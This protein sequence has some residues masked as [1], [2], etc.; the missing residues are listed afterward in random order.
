MA[1]TDSGATRTAAHLPKPDSTVEADGGRLAPAAPLSFGDY[2]VVGDLGAGGMGRVYKAA[3]RKLSRYVAIK[4][5]LTPDAFEASRFRGEASITARLEHPNITR[6]FEIETTADGHPYLVLEYAEGGSLDREL[7]GQPQEPRRAAEMAETLAKAIQYAHDQ[8]VIHRDLKPANVLRAK[9]GTLKLTDFGLAKQYELSS[10]LTPSGAL[11]GTPSYM[12]PEQAS[13]S[14]RDVGPAAD[15]Y[16]LGAI[17]Y[18]LLTGRP[19]FRGVTMVETLEQVRWADPAPPSRLAPRLPRDLGTI[20]LKCLAKAPA[21][22]Y[23]TAADLAADLRR[24]MDGETI[25]ARPAPAWERGWR[26]FRRRPWESA[27]VAAGVLLAVLLAAGAVYAM[28]QEA[29]K[30]HD[31]DL[32]AE[33][34]RA[35]HL[36]REAEREAA[37]RLRER[38]EK[39]RRALDAIKHHL[40][41]GELRS[42]RGLNNLHG[43]LADYYKQYIDEALT[44]PSPD[45]AALAELAYGVGEQAHQSGRHD[46]AGLLFGQARDGFAAVAGADPRHRP[47]LGDALVKVARVLYD[48]NRDDEAAAACAEAERLWAAVYAASDGRARDTA[49]LQL[50]EV[51][52]IRGELAR[53]R[54]DIPAARDAF[55]RAI[56]HRRRVAGLYPGQSVDLLLAAEPAERAWAVRCL[57]ELGRG[58]GYRGDEFLTLGEVPDADRDYWDSHRVRQKVFD[59]LKAA[60]PA[61]DPAEFELARFQLGRSWMNLA[62]VQARHRAYATAKQNAHEALTHREALVKSGP[63]HAEYLVDMAA[64]LT[65]VGRLTLLERRGEGDDRRAALAALTQ[66]AEQTVSEKGQPGFRTR[67]VLAD[68]HAVR[69]QLLADGTDP[70]AR[71]AAAADARRVEAFLDEAQKLYP[72]VLR[73][74]FHRVTMQALL[75]DHDGLPPDNPRWQAVLDGL[76]RVLAGGFRDEHPDDIRTRPCFRRLAADPRFVRLFATARP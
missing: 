18:E 26:Q 3:D 63:N 47:R 68:A 69:A 45:R 53:R 67:E 24:W 56:D 61:A 57:R 74:H 52:H 25:A 15:V 51:E 70:A 29:E 62:S 72:N 41:T 17:L 60:G 66:A 13:G 1:P 43:E 22:R 28:R 38:G 34:E 49:A 16:G 20:C 42:T 11:M 59:V 46:T 50:A 23:A 54:Y 19:P 4:V 2:D 40:T 12:A 76:G 48:R 7:R 21:R 32:A 58:Y 44:D 37:A 35:D 55:S 5:L 27:A 75:A 64:N 71:A 65:E 8:G 39:S 6:I 10:G 31:R 33:R 14:V 9:D 73:Y 36:R 30:N